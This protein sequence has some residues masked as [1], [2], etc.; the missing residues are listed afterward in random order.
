M[1]S[2]G[3][4]IMITVSDDCETINLTI[5]GNT[6]MLSEEEAAEIVSYLTHL[7][8]ERKEAR[9]NRSKMVVEN[10][11][12]RPKLGSKPIVLNES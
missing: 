11:L 10:N 4:L 2:I 12:Y 5:R 3:D 7:I 6:V 1:V 9:N 8:I